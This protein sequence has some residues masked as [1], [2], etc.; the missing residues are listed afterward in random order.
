MATSGSSNPTDR[1]SSCRWSAPAATPAEA[2][3]RAP[4]RAPVR[5]AGC[6]SSAAPATL[7]PVIALFGLAIFVS[8]GLV[9]LVQPMTAK[10]LLPTF[11]GSPQVWTAS[12]VFFQGALL[13]GYAYA[14][15]SI[16]RL[17]LRRQPMVHAVL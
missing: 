6:A 10:L 13:A 2:P 16:R 15:W 17:G 9:F 4:R 5:L 8:A 1:S 14:H 3:D 11:G 12:M 7:R